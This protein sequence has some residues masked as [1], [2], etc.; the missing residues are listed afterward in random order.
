MDLLVIGIHFRSTPLELREHVFYRA[1]EIPQVLYRL[2]DALPETELLLL[3]TCNR[4]EFYLASAEG[5]ALDPQTLTRTCLTVRP[6]AAGEQLAGRAYVHHGI[7]AIRHLMQVATSLDSLVVGETEILGQVKQAYQLAQDAGTAGTVL[8]ALLQHVFRVAKRVRTETDI[9]LG[10]VSVG[11]I[12]V[13][14]T[15]K[16]F[17][18][19]NTKTVMVVGAGEIGEQTLKALLDRGVREPYIVNRSPE[20]G[21][22]LAQRYGG[23]ALPFDRLED[24]LPRTDILISS[25][26]APSC[27]ITADM[28]QRAMRL[29]RNRPSLMIDLAVPRDIEETVGQIPNVYHYNIDDLETIAAENLTKRHDSVAKARTIIAAEAEDVELSLQAGYLGLAELMQ[30]LDRTVAEIEDA[31]IARAFA[32]DRVAPFPETCQACRE[33]IR[34]MLHRALAKMVAHPKKVLNE[35]ARNGTWNEVSRA[36]EL[37]YGMNRTPEAGTEPTARPSAADKKEENSGE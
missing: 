5:V 8:N 10:R 25:T 34:H 29:R 7:D 35:A 11:L 16:V 21:R 14:L 19:L 12:A 6:G 30:Q 22:D 4:T 20:R 3:S 36:A 27:V 9:S 33:A 18:S 13:D 31:E 37:L 2:R 28:V 1:D 24:F 23:T 17:D 26:S 15:A 32:K